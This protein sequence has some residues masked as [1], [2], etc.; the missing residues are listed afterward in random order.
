[1]KPITLFEYGI[2]KEWRPEE[3]DLLHIERLNERMGDKILSIRY[4]KGSPIIRAN[5]CVGV[6]KFG[7]KMIQILPKVD[8]DD[9]KLA[10]Q[11]LLYLLSYTRKL[12]IKE[13]S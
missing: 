11:N 7:R 13:Q 12:N 4:K 6:V 9:E 5:S 8:N 10:T 3:I 1:M 2:S